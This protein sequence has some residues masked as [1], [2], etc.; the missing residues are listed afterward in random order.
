MVTGLPAARRIGRGAKP[1]FQTSIRT[2][3]GPAAWGAAEAG[4]AR[5]YASKKEAAILIMA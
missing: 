4:A 5:A 2:W 3:A 1:K